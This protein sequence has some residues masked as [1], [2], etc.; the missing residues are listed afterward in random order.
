MFNKKTYAE[1][2]INGVTLLRRQ[3]TPILTVI[4]RSRVDVEENGVGLNGAG[5]GIGLRLEGAT[6]L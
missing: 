2:V 4:S 6:E 3:D 5:F 1:A